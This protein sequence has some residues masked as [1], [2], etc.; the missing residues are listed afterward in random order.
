MISQSSTRKDLCCSEAQALATRRPQPR[1]V[2][3]A[4]PAAGQRNKDPVEA[5][6]ARQTNVGRDRPNHATSGHLNLSVARKMEC[7][8]GSVTQISDTSQE[9]LLTEARRILE[10]AVSGG[11]RSMPSPRVAKA[12]DGQ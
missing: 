11:V 3:L 9:W 8:A 7:S 5:A 12:P 4:V 10:E 6:Y 2:D 1:T